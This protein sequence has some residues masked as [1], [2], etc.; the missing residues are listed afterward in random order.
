QPGEIQE[1]AV[2]LAGAVKS[3]IKIK[4]LSPEGK[5]V[6]YY[7]KTIPLQNGSG[8]GSFRTALNDQA[9]QW[10]VIAKDVITGFETEQYFELEPVK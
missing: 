8:A 1:F 3:A 2:S 4:V 7:S 6:R 5:D 10:K 9:G